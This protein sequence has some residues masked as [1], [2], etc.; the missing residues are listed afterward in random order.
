MTRIKIQDL[1]RDM[2][3]SQGEMRKVMGGWD[4]IP[5]PDVASFLNRGFTPIPLPMPAGRRFARK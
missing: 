2:K 4:P 5:M 1:P 3:I